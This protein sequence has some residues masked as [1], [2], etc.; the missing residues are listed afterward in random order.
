[1]TWTLIEPCC[2]AA[3]LA[4]HMSGVFKRTLLPYQGSKWKLRAPLQALL[5]KRNFTG[6]PRRTLLSDIGPWGLV[7][8]YLL[9][10]DCRVQ[11]IDQ[12]KKW[13]DEDPREVYDRI[14]NHPSGEG[15]PYAA[16]YLFLQRLAFNGKALS[17]Q[18]GIWKSPGFNDGTAYGTPKTDNFGAINPMLPSLVRTLEAFRWDRTAGW[19]AHQQSATDCKFPIDD[20]TVVYFDP[21]YQNTTTYPAGD[22]PRDDVIRLAREWSDQ[23]ALVVI[24]E[25]EEISEL[26]WESECLIGDPDTES[27]FRGSSPEWITFNGVRAP[28]EELDLMQFFNLE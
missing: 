14:H 18:G 7:W 25:A 23:G 20:R 6:P 27:T 28:Q 21:P 3:A 9:D 5:V 8:G 2:G 17:D 15:A 4:T 13:L 24:S 19:E 1:M 11:I 16:E 12:L 10:E 26:G 22:L